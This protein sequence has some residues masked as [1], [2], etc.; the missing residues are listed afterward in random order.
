MDEDKGSL[1]VTIREGQ[2]VVVDVDGEKVE[3]KFVKAG[4]RNKASVQVTAAR[5]HAIQRIAVAEGK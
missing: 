3:I 5:R 1:T 2:T 4:G